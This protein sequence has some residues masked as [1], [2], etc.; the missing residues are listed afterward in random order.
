MYQ[1]KGIS[2]SDCRAA[3]GCRMHYLPAEALAGIADQRRTLHFQ[4]GET[5]F[6]QDDQ[7]AYFYGIQSGRVQL[8][9]A[10]PS[11]EMSFLMAGAGQWLGHRDALLGSGYAHG[12]R[13]LEDTVVCKFEAETLGGLLEN[14]PKFAAA[15]TKDLAAGWARAEDQS[16][17]LGARRISERLAHFLLN[18]EAGG[19]TAGAVAARFQKPPATH[20]RLA[21]KRQDDSVSVD[22][23]GF[24]C[25]P[26]A[27]EVRMDLTRELVGS[28]LGTTTESVIR[29]LSD[30]R[31]RGWI[32]LGKGKVTLT[33]RDE[34]EK[35][36]TES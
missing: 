21:G 27:P 18:L 1:T 15:V 26:M 16:Y 28:L 22:D 3:P 6:H 5:L 36:V 19:V 12:A 32:S 24:D 23:G 7:S 14:N 13:A 2:C 35:L 20:L 34:L 11:K 25:E 31:D 30:F 33:K 9:R 17:N 29:T 4:R 10:G 8:F